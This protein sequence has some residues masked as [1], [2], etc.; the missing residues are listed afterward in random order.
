MIKFF[1]DF[2]CN[3]TLEGNIIGQENFKGRFGKIAASKLG[4]SQFYPYFSTFS[5]PENRL[6]IAIK[7][8]VFLCKA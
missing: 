2:S 5:L 6:P 7:F 3:L 1:E 8:S 4:F